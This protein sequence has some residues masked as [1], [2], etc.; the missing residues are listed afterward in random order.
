M[1][2]MIIGSSHQYMVDVHPSG[3]MFTTE[4]E[5]IPIDGNM[6]NP[7]WSLVYD[8]NGNLGSVYQMIGTGSYVNVITWVGYS[9]TLPGIGSRVTTI[10]SWSA[11]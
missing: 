9:G 2:E 1:P 11:V 5:V 4:M 10:G 8:S 7:M 6:N 3:G